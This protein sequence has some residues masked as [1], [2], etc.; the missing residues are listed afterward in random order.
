[1]LRKCTKLGRSRELY[2]PSGPHPWTLP[3]GI[4]TKTIR[5]AGLVDYFGPDLDLAPGNVR[6]ISGA[7][8]T[9]LKSR[10]EYVIS[11]ALAHDLAMHTAHLR[12]QASVSTRPI[13]PSLKMPD[14]TR[15]R[16]VGYELIFPVRFANIKE[17]E[18]CLRTKSTEEMVTI[19]TRQSEAF[20]GMVRRFNASVA[21]A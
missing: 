14:R 21:R 1:M 3:K 15:E 13:K 2:L 18:D 7:A 5:S 19:L 20:L 10:T 17:L 12:A 9:S 11:I 6:M 8:R 16:R 4:A